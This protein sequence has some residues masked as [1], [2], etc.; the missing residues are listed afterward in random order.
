MQHGCITSACCILHFR[1]WETKDKWQCKPIE[2]DGFCGCFRRQTLGCLQQA[3]SGTR[4]WESYPPS[5]ASGFSNKALLRHPVT[6]YSKWMCLKIGACQKL[7][8]DGWFYLLVISG[9]EELYL[10]L[11]VF[12][13]E[14]SSWKSIDHIGFMGL[15]YLP[16]FD[17]FW[18]KI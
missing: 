12:L 3:A 1:T 2:I 16:T 13:F 10:E 8:K 11:N 7:S 15:V 5:K 17:W 9:F 4:L 6:Q 18:C 14:N